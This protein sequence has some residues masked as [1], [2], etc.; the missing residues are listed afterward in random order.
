MGKNGIGKSTLLRVL[1][2]ISAPDYGEVIYRGENLLKGAAEIRN[3]ILY[4]GHHPALYPS[5]SAVEN[6]SLAMELRKLKPDKDRII[7]TLIAFGLESQMKDPITIY[8]QGML[9]RLKLTLASVLDWNLLLFD[10]PFTGLDAEG[11]NRVDQFLVQCRNKGKSVILVLHN[12]DRALNYCSR[13]IFL[14]NGKVGADVGYK[15]NTRE[16]IRRIFNS[17]VG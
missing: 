12:M 11:V 6:L 8:S 17:I 4:L 1:A 16:D 2:R 15:E 7:K 13:F 14:K 10:E 3:S 9:Q 5:L